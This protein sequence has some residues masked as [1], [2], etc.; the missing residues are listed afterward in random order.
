MKIT[1]FKQNGSELTVTRKFDANL[2]LVWRAWTEAELLDQWWAP[3]PWK[4]ETSYMEFKIGGYRVYA[5]VGPAGERHVGRT[6]YKAIDKPRS[7]EGEDAFCDADGNINSAFPISKFTNSFEQ[8]GS[9]TT[10]IVITLYDSV[11][12]LQQVIDMGMKEGL[13]MAYD[14]LDNV[15]KSIAG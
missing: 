6:D 15:L 5:M 4:S 3:A 2:G 1:D 12:Q 14:Q 7:F 13:S 9:Q 8:S 10:V 11:E